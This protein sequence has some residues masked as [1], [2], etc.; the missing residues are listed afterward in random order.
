MVM[1]SSVWMWCIVN[2]RVSPLA[3]AVSNPRFPSTTKTAARAAHRPARDSCTADNKRRAR[4]AGTGDPTSP[5]LS[6]PPVGDA[7]PAFRRATHD[8]REQPTISLGSV[9]AGLPP[10]PFPPKYP[11]DSQG[12]WQKN[13]H[14]NTT[15]AGLS[16]RWNRLIWHLTRELL[17]ARSIGRRI[18]LDE[19]VDSSGRPFGDGDAIAGGPGLDPP[20]TAGKVRAR[21]L[22]Q[23]DRP[24]AYRRM[25]SSARTGAGKRCLGNG[26]RPMQARHSAGRNGQSPGALT[27]KTKVGTM[28]R[29]PDRR[30]CR[31]A[32]RQSLASCR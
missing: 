16:K 15:E 11:F 8:G 21:H 4:S 28:A 29:R 24:Q 9:K 23:R 27:R 2:V 3:I 17:R 32:D 31:P 7:E 19:R 18:G 20:H 30:E 25:T 22:P 1:S 10:A 26:P 6:T 13:A 5:T 14:R 12:V